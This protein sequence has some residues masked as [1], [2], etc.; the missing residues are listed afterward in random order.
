MLLSLAAAPAAADRLVA[1][2]DLAPRGTVSAEAGGSY[3]RASLDLPMDDAYIHTVAA[4][5][6]AR[7]AVLDGVMVGLAQGAVI[8]QRLEQFSETVEVSER[9]G[10]GDLALTADGLLA[11]GAWKA[12]AS[13]AV[14]LPTGT[15]ELSND[16][17]ALDVD[18]VGALRTSER[19][20]LFA[21][22]GHH[23]AP[24]PDAIELT[25]GMH[26]RDDNWSFVPRVRVTF[27][28]P[29]DDADRGS[30]GVAGELGAAIELVPDV[31]FRLV[32]S[33]ARDR[34]VVDSQLFATTTLGVF[35]FVQG[36][37][38]FF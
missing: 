17:A 32:A 29:V 22:A 25:V 33:L 31:S 30:V 1:P 11:F 14:W 9:N 3:T 23:A 10:I 36:T 2:S 24:A 19:V 35:G 13:L 34:I 27:D 18:L 4:S 26:A 28:S 8:D 16:R 37:R 6:R 15:D 12:G 5:L 7:V 38:D 21:T 20:E